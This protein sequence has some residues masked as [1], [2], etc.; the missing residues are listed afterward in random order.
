ME[1]LALGPD[2]H[3]PLPLISLD[4]ALERTLLCSDL[5]RQEL[6][7]RLLADAG[8][9]WLHPLLWVLPRR[10]RLAP[11][12]LPPHLQG[13]S[14]LL[15]EGLISPVFLTALVDDLAHLWPPETDAVPTPLQR[16]QADAVVAS[17]ARS[18][19]LPATFDQLEER[20][21]AGAAAQNAST[22]PPSRLPQLSQGL[23]WSNVGLD[24]SQPA[25][26]RLS[27]ALMAQVFNRLAANALT[28]ERFVFEGCADGASLLAA[29]QQRDWCIRARLRCS[30][31]SFGFGAALEL[32]DQPP[33]QIPLA[34]P[35]R[36]GL[37]DAAG[38]EATTL[39]PHTA[40][41]LELSREARAIRL[42]WFQGTGGLCGWDA[43]NDL[44]RPWQNDRQN[45]T[46]RY[47]G[48]PFSGAELPMLMR[49]SELIALVHN[50]EATARHLRL[51]GYGSLGFCIDSTALLQLALRGS[52]DLYPLVLPGLWRE[53]LDRRAADLARS[54]P[55]DGEP[56]AAYRAAL[57]DLPLDLSHHGGSAAEAWRRLQASLP[58]NS[59]FELVQQLRRAA[60]LPP[61]GH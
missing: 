42:Q 52:C 6:I 11:P 9:P 56:I 50:Q 46:V 57:A 45:G 21:H 23:R 59:P 44:H 29:L 37:L 25:E 5:S 8:H 15:Q 49:L 40:L 30:I 36:T 43:L 55:A 53:R 2:W 38:E 10:W 34:L 48:E 18:L 16:W 22:T 20:A 41:E 31:A 54:G 47:L 61:S 14:A 58:L 19:P 12:W 24:Y 13:V 26:A 7:Q 28:S 35:M 4:E 1:P 33:R 51:G 32:P 60:P 3:D 39:L 17:P 27:N